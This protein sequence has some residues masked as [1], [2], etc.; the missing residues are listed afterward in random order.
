MRQYAGHGH[1][2][3]DEPA[4]PLPVGARADRPVGRRSTCR[5]RWAWTPTIR[6]P[7]ARSARPASRSTRIEDME[8]LFDGIPLDRVTTSMTINATAAILLLLYE[9]VAEEQGVDAADLA[10]TVQN[11]LLKEYAARG[12]YIYPPKPSMR[13]ITDLF[14][15]CDERHPEVEHHLDQRLPHARGR[16]D[17]G[18]GDRVHAGRTASRTCRPRSTPGW[19][20]DDFAPRLSFFFA[21]HH[22]LLRGDREVPRGAADVGADHARALR[23]EGPAV[24][25]AAVPHADRRRDADGAAAREQHR[26]DGARGA[27]RRARRHAVAAHQRVRRGA[28]AADRA[29]PRRSRCAPSR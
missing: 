2:R 10:G 11:D 19:T 14:A 28:R 8:R 29:T 27:G 4:V 24:A 12:T 26:P 3:R 23:G 5:R 21:C 6:A 17:G 7:R 15:Y 1:R 22:A 18:A 9:L 20:I 16:R 13:L 25:D